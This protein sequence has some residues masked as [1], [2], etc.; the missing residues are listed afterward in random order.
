MPLNFSRKGTCH[1][2]STSVVDLQATVGNL[3]NRASPLLLNTSKHSEQF[4][5]TA[6]DISNWYIS[7]VSFQDKKKTC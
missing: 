5:A 3:Y 7:C 6:K 1:S 4:H 2:E